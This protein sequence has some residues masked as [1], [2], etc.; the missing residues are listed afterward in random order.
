[1][2]AK[3]RWVPGQQ[4]AHRWDI[5]PGDV[6]AMRHQFAAGYSLGNLMQAYHL[7][8]DEA[9]AILRGEMFADLSGPLWDRLP[10]PQHRRPGVLR[11]AA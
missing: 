5:A 7:T 6:V 4:T 10:N 3:G 11:R 2:H 9:R 1:M 8:Y